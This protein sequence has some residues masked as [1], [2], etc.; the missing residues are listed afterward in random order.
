MSVIFDGFKGMRFNIDFSN[1]KEDKM[2][3]KANAKKMFKLMDL[4]LPENFDEIDESDDSN[5]SN[6]WEDIDDSDESEEEDEET[7]DSE[8]ES[9][10]VDEDI[11][12]RT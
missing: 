2:I 7:E 6:E 1:T 5:D 4:P 10:E 12:Y 8:E 11:D 3:L 9:E